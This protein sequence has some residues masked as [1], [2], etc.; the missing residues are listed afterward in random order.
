[1]IDRT[2]N[3]IK[4]ALEPV[5]KAISAVGAVV[6]GLMIFMLIISVILRKAFNT[7][8]TGVFELTEYGMVMITFMCMSAQYFKPDSMVMDTFIEKFPKKGR[9]INDSIVF[10]IDIIILALLAWQL[11]VYG[12]NTFESA[13]VSKL[14]E[15][16]V[17]PFA[18]LGALCT[19]LL[20][21][22]FI[23]KFLFALRD[24]GGKE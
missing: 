8:L 15:I 9:A 3:F 10:L 7:N 18:W 13:Q 11:F 21:L 1:M 22:I 14:L 20:T 23:M 6:L 16:P 2:A 19:L 17:Y 4:K 12:F 5:A 24:I